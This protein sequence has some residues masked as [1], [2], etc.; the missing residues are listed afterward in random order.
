MT[1]APVPAA[2][3]AH[4]SAAPLTNL[5]SAWRQGDR[6]A[7]DQVL[8]GGHAELL[9]MA[10]SRLRGSETPSLAADDLV[11][12]PLLRVLLEPPA[13]ESRGHFFVTL[14]T[15]LRR[16]ARHPA[17]ARPRPIATPRPCST[18][19]PTCRTRRRSAAAWPNWAPTA[20]VSSACCACSAWPT[21]ARMSHSQ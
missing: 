2:R 18:R 19:R 8:R 13:W 9:R 15:P 12:E 1:S 3:H 11:S 6:S 21:S 14:S 16:R 7:M 4:P 17:T 10:S 20:R 5:L